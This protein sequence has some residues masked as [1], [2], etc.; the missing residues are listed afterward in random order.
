[1][2][3]C[4]AVVT[5]S[6]CPP[7]HRGL[8]RDRPIYGELFAVIA[9]QVTAGIPHDPASIAAAL[10]EAGTTAGHH[11]VQLRYALT[12]ATLSGAMAASAAHY[13]RSVISAAYRRG[14]HRAAAALAHAAAELPQDQLFTHLLGIGCEQRTATLRLTHISGTLS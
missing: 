8:H 5:A 14:F 10:T 2:P 13:A 3:R 4:V 12:Q 7:C 1:M 6:R 9:G 11:G